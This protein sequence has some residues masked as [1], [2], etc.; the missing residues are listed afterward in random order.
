M[1]WNKFLSEYP[2]V[3][4]FCFLSLCILTLFLGISSNPI[5]TN[6]TYV[7]TFIYPKLFILWAIF[8][9]VLFFTVFQSI[10]ILTD[11]QNKKI[12]ILSLCILISMLICPILPYDLKK[13]PILS[14]LHIYTSMFSC[15]SMIIV[16]FKFLKDYYFTDYKISD[17]Y[18]KYLYSVM[19]LNLFTFLLFGCVT[20]LL[21]IVYIISMSI[22]TYSLWFN[23]KKERK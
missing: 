6:L 18:L 20:S 22:F 9:S 2:I 4:F 5:Q 3:F 11:Y 23:V 16:S 8:T 7:G 14:N 12:K 15:V 19:F 1:K 21:E 17:K 13:Y 10:F